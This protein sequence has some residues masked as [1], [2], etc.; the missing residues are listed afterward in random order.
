MA[1]QSPGSGQEGIDVAPQKSPNERGGAFERNLG[2]LALRFLR[3][4]FKS[5]MGE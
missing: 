3:K 5:K 2:D 1:H 4:I